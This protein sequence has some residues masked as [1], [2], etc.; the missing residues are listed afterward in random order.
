M[1][2]FVHLGF[3]FRTVSF[4][5]ILSYIKVQYRSYYSTVKDT[6]IHFVSVIM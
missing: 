4:V 3:F 2:E 1:V 5:L 6:G